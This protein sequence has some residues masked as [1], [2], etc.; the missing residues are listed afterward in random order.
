MLRLETGTK[1]ISLEILKRALNWCVKILEMEVNNIAKVVYNR[2]VKLDRTQNNTIEY[3]C[4]S[5]LK[6]L[7]VNLGYVTV[8][9]TQRA[10]REEINS[11][12]NKRTL[13]MQEIDISL[14]DNSKYNEHYKQIK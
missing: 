14:L 10:S 1:H 8:W 13:K 4:V 9:E 3:N 12:L 7:I 2:L 11:I 5:Q 6:T